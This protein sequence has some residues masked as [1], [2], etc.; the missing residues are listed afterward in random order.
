MTETSIPVAV[1][2]LVDAIN[3]GDTDG[4]VATFTPSGVVDDWGRVLSGPA[5]VR[6]WAESDAIGAGA[7]MT[8]LAADTRGDVTELR[9]RWKS[10]VFTG[11]ST[12]FVTLDGD[13]IALFR[14]PPHS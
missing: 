5:G 11:E 7:H 4:F 3:A 2:R 14:I 12:A 1:Q 13:R 10:R 8:V 6:R 9:F